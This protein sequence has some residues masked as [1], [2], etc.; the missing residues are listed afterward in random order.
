MKLFSK[1][2]SN[3]K[4]GRPDTERLRQATR[5]GRLEQNLSRD[6]AINQAD[7]LHE[8][9]VL[10]LFLHSAGTLEEM[11]SLFL[12]RA[13]RVTG[14]IVT[15][16]L[17]L[18]RRREVLTASQ[19]ASIDDASLEQA[20]MAANEN[21]ADVEFPMPVRSRLRE[22]M[23]SGEVVVTSDL[24]EIFGSVF[25]KE[26]CDQIRHQLDVSK[27]AVVPLVMEGESFGLCVF[28][29]S[30]G[31]PDVEVLELAAGHCTLALKALIAGEE[32][33]RFG[34]IDPVTWAHSR[35]F[36]LEAL[37]GEVVRAR[38]FG[39][40]LSVIFLDLDEF[41]EFNE[42]YG[43]TMGDR[44]LRAVAMTLASSVALPEIVARYGGDEFAVLLPESH[45]AMAAE[46]TSELV[47]KLDSLSVFEDGGDGRTGVSASFA[48]VSY[49]EDGAS[50]EELLTAAEVSLEQ[51][52][53]ERRAMR[54]PKRQLTPVQQLRLSGRRHVA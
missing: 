13:P 6:E 51:S 5:P 16:P 37:E 25:S 26:I 42:N 39:R 8:L 52:K 14:A 33:T 19:L 23:D 29:F 36:F 46:V 45:R 49:P 50:R 31:E 35:G 38:R 53:E 12:E 1:R 15:Y 47:E 18:D 11:L 28:L 48:I 10:S 44:V 41:G 22:I 2:G 4:S 40:G 7:R 27:A 9:A 32:T 43:H 21:L 17:L 54:M 24:K 3:N 34:G 20:S 30:G